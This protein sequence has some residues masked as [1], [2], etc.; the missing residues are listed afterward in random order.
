MPVK[1][2]KAAPKK[3]AAVKRKA[4][5]KKRVTTSSVTVTRKKSTTVGAATSSVL[6]SQL[7]QRHKENMAAAFI[8]KEFAKKKTDKRKYQKKINES[9]A[10]IRKLK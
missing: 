4:A 9:R 10:A 6:T 2:R 1:K 5:P 3:R 7:I 8:Q